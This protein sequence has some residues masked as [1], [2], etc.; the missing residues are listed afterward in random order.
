MG[1]HIVMSKAFDLKG[2]A[3]KAEQDVSPRHVLWTLHH[4]LNAEIHQPNSECVSVQDKLLARITGSPEHWALARSLVAKL[5]AD[6][7]VFCAGEDVG[8]PLAMLCRMTKKR[9]KVAISVM[10]P[11]RLR[12]RTC[13]KVFQ[14]KNNINLFLTNTASKSKFLREEF[15][16]FEQQVYQLPEQTDE[17]FFKPGS[18]S[19]QKARPLIFSAGLEQRDYKTLA[20]ATKDLEVDVKVCAISPNASKSTR[21]E[22][23]EEI[24]ENMTFQPYDWPDFRWM[25]QNAD[26]VVVSLLQNHYSAGLTS[27]MEAIACRRPTVL[28]RTPG[29]GEELIARGVVV[30]VEPGDAAGMRQAILNLLEKPEEAEAL[31]EKAYQYFLAHHTSTQFAETL[32]DRLVSL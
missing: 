24:P 20:A 29:F 9:L 7:V 11:E 12:F 31:A 16:L 23:P 18:R 30:G 28:T 19:S 10:A 26:V 2:M 6:D 32:A 14:L 1:Y 13:L 21:A 22:F 3:E 4:K 15:S 25:Y 17:K 8:I 5:Q 27:A